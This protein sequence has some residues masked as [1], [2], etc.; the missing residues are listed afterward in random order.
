MKAR[1]AAQVTGAALVA[2]CAAVTPATNPAANADSCPDVE[3]VFARGSG[4]PPGVGGVGRAFVD[5]VRSQ[6]GR[7]TVGVYAVDYA[8]SSNFSDRP[9]IAR[10]VAA[11]VRDEADHLTW[12]VR[13]CPDT[14]MVLGGYSQGAALTGM[15]TSTP[16]PA[17]VADH[18][19]AVVFFGKPSGEL[20]PRYSVTRII[21]G[22]RYAFKT[23]DLC[24][25]GDAVCEGIL[26]GPR[27][28]H[29]LYPVN[30]M[31]ARGAVYAVSKL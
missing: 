13:Y 1:W 14:K 19:A 23:L 2:V 15:L 11:G 6:A 25:P 27:A 12:M 10:T 22:K 29:R 26:D 9:E 17:R 21:I 28:A 8:A 24:A 20:L 7:R 30:G 5:A 31:V 18:V 4:E 16:L 3:V